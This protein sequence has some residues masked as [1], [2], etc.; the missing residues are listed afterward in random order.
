MKIITISSSYE[1]IVSRYSFDD[2]KNL[3]SDTVI[4]DVSAKTTETQNAVA[5]RFTGNAF[6]SVVDRT[7][8]QIPNLGPSKLSSNKVRIENDKIRPE[9]K[10]ISDDEGQYLE[11]QSETRISRWSLIR[12]LQIV[13]KLRFIFT[14]RCYKSRYKYKVIVQYKF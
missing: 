14:I 5:N 3:Q 10:F 6:E 11:L 9:F 1:N 8:S 7:K 4:R 13:I 12:Y 2:D